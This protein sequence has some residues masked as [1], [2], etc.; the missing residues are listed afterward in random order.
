MYLG[1]QNNDQLG[2]RLSCYRLLVKL[3]ELSDDYRICH[4][5]HTR[6]QLVYGTPECHHSA[7]SYV[8]QKLMHVPETFPAK[9]YHPASP[10]Q[11]HLQVLC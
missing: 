10:W 4:T 7:Y 3:H 9:A 1:L 8:S 6:M 5:S 11:L 2:K